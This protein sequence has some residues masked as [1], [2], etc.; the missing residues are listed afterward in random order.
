MTRNEVR[1]HVKQVEAQLRKGAVL[2]PKGREALR[3][4]KAFLLEHD[5]GTGAVEARKCRATGALRVLYRPFTQADDEDWQ[6]ICETHGY[7]L[8]TPTRQE[9]SSAMADPNW[10]EECQAISLKR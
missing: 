4:L 2:S 5:H 9:G 6:I 1:T 3:K 8:S 10:C 7:T